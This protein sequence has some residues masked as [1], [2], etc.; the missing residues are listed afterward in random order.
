MTFLSPPQNVSSLMLW[1]CLILSHSD[2][3]SQAPPILSLKDYSN[4]LLGFSALSFLF[5]L[6]HAVTQ[7]HVSCVTCSEDLRVCQSYSS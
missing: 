5:P 1:N 7:T 4:L 6:H 3:L 2:S